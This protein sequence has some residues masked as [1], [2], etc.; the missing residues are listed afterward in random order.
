MH[1][2]QALPPRNLLLLLL[3]TVALAGCTTI[4]NRRDLYFPQRVWGPYT[5]MLHKGIPKQSP[6][7]IALPKGT[8]GGKNVVKPQG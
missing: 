2:H 4:E 1:K 8:G 3:L 5:K 7:T 6:Q